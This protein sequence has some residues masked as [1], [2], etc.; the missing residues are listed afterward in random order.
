[1][2]FE[3]NFV[4]IYNF[5]LSLNE[6]LNKSFKI[7]MSWII[8]KMT[9]DQTINRYKERGVSSSK[10]EVHQVVDK[11]DR[12]CFPGAFCKITNDILTLN[13]NLCNIIH[14]GRKIWGVATGA[15]GVYEIERNSY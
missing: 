15:V 3:Y 4:S 1:M 7:L 5:V 9:S 11:L 13:D 12:G 2:T 14:S 10:D 8:F 6:W